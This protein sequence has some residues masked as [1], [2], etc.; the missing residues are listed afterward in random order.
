MDSISCDNNRKLSCFRR[1]TPL[2]IFCLR[3]V[4]ERPRLLRM[5]RMLSPGV[6]FMLLGVTLFCLGSLLVKIAGQ[7]LP[8]S[9]ILFCRG[10]IGLGVCW[11]ILR[12]TGVGESLLGNRRWLLVFRGLFG[13]LSLYFTFQ[14][15]ILLPLADSMTIV[16]ARPVIIALLAA[17]FLHEAMS[18]R[19]IIAMFISL[20]G[21]AIICRPSFLFGM[22]DPLDPA[23]VALALAAMVVSAMS[24]VTV[25]ALT[26]TEH[27][28]IVMIYQ[29][30]ATVLGTPLMAATWVMPQ[31][32]EWAMLLGVGLLMNAGQYFMTRGYALEPAGR[33]SAVGYIQIVEAAFLSWL[34]LDDAPDIWT[35]AGAALIIGGTLYIGQHKHHEE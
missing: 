23:G 29:P 26:R 17:I 1:V 9:E 27:P 20:A 25:R 2:G 8:A 7:R 35:W 13:F 31:G 33:L 24:I 10:V 18:G 16:Q 3:L 11:S 21:V 34:F 12:R 30:Y 22:A 28:A 4:R 32:W 14:A 15:M 6:R 19:T 5:L